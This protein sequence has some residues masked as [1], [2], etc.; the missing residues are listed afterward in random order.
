[1]ELRDWLTALAARNGAAPSSATHYHTF[2][3]K[4]RAEFPRLPVTEA[5][6]HAIGGLLG[7]KF[8]T[9]PDLAAAIRSVL[10]EA[11]QPPELTEEERNT[12]RWVAY[13]ERRIR[14][15]PAAK[16][17]ILSLLRSTCWAA[18]I[19]VDDGHSLRAADAFD[20][21]FWKARGK[22]VDHYGPMVARLRDRAE[23]GDAKAQE[24]LA[25][26]RTYSPEAR[27]AE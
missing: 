22:R 21:A 25:Q 15:Q 2:A 8:P 4:I 12:S 19:A 17:H 23:R 27:A 16:D 9:W 26:L 3:A 1:M 24:R 7:G 11:G 20:N 13:A 5:Y 6:A 10:S 18:Y 14:E